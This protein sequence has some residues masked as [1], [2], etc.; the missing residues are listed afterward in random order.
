MMN[1]EQLITE[2]CSLPLEQRAHVVERL[3]QSL[4]ASNPEIDQAWLGLARRRQE[5]LASGKVPGIPGEE[6]FKRISRR[7]GG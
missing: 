7:F 3:L 2:A 4:S 1:T 6:V 5:E